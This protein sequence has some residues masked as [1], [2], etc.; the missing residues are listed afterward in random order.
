MKT[1]IKNLDEII[2]ATCIVCNLS[3]EEFFSRERLRYLVDARRIAYSAIRDIYGTPLLEMGRYFSK[4]HATIL[5]HLRAH[6]DLIQW[7]EGYSNRYKAV[8]RVFN[9]TTSHQ[10]I[11]DILNE[12]K[13]LKNENK[14]LLDKIKSQCKE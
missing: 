5:H 4:N 13:T 12:I 9:E 6:R 2:N 3:R 10:S 8:L 11:D 14:A 7:D 1:S